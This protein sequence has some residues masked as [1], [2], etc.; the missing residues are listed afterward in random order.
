MHKTALAGLALFICSCTG[1]TQTQQSQPVQ[2]TRDTAPRPSD[3]GTPTT[4][5]PGPNDSHPIGSRPQMT[6]DSRPSP[7][8][9][10]PSQTGVPETPE[11]AGALPVANEVAF[12]TVSLKATGEQHNS[13]YN[14]ANWGSVVA[15]VETSGP[16]GELQYLKLLDL[17]AADHQPR[18]LED[19]SQTGTRVAFPVI[20]ASRV[21]WVSFR[22][23]AGGG[24]DWQIKQ[25][26]RASG[27]T[28]VVVNGLNVSRVGPV[29][30]PHL[31]LSQ[32]LLA[33]DTQ[34]DVAGK[35]EAESIHVIDLSTG[36]ET[37]VIPSPSV[38]W[39]LA[40]S[41]DGVLFTAAHGQG[42][43]IVDSETWFARNDRQTFDFGPDGWEVASDGETLVWVQAASQVTG[44]AATQGQVVMTAIATDPS[45]HELSHAYTQPGCPPLCAV[46]GARW[47][48]AGGG[49][50][51]WQE[52]NPDA[53]YSLVVW[54]EA[55]GRIARLPL[56]GSGFVNSIGGGTL[57]TATVLTAEPDEGQQL[58]GATVSDLKSAIPSN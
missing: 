30:V 22:H 19:G 53:I 8:A 33:Y 24:L 48:A 1:P 26:D 43:Q 21:L 11:P 54:D 40:L 17:A 38:V 47:P 5:T 35:P 16:T 15:F 12:L 6:P 32:G 10:G 50:V 18:V 4:Q 3:A 58:L 20:D 31:A 28:S 9:A 42:D 7:S 27:E 49:I 25:Y 36:S 14:L 51:A 57:V 23:H 45:P 55:T 44:N 52:S 39:G 37:A 29:G 2:A 13:I 56:E 34:A 46:V 41:D